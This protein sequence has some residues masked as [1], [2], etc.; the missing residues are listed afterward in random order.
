VIVHISEPIIANEVVQIDTKPSNTG[1]R[2]PIAPVDSL[3]SKK[4]VD[5]VRDFGFHQISPLPM[6]PAVR[7]N[8][9]QKQFNISPDAKSFSPVFNFGSGVQTPVAFEHF[10]LGFSEG[11]KF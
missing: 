6:I 3:N 4:A 7:R 8:E 11:R 5:N 2:P 10:D 1:Q 9:V